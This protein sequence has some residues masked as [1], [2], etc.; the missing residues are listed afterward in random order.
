MNP[1]T[2]QELM[3]I[4]QLGIDTAP[5]IYFIERH[6]TYL[7]LMR[8]LI[9]RLDEGQIEGYTSVITLTEVL[10]LPKQRHDS[11]L[12]G[13]YRELLQ[14]SRH[15]TLLP[16]TTDIAELAAQLRA[17]YTIKTPD[18]LQ[19]ATAILTN[20]QAFLTNDKRLKVVKELPMLV[21]DELIAIPEIMEWVKS[22]LESQ[23]ET[24]D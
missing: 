22:E 23:G 17:C 15:F 19:I 11:K 8:Y 2:P 9:N 1:I 20:C 18:A 24:T 10:I 12:E 7:E 3:T 13:L 21:L 16:V 6:P 14:S 4:T 5:L